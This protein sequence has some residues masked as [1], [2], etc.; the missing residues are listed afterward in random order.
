MQ[1]IKTTINVWIG[2]LTSREFEFEFKYA[3]TIFSP[4]SPSVR[5]GSDAVLFMSRTQFE[6]GPTQIDKST[7]LDSDAVLF[8]RS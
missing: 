1:R 5:P 8:G 2:L 7:P 4:N 3:V 6:F